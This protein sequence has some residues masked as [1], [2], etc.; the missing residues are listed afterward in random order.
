MAAVGGPVHSVDLGQMALE[1]PS[2]L[3]ANSW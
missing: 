1:C 3:H 2:R